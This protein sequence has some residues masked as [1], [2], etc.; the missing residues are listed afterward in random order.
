MVIFSNA[1][2]LY[3]YQLKLDL[4]NLSFW[5]SIRRIPLKKGVLK[6]RLLRLKK[7]FLCPLNVTRGYNS[8]VSLC[9][10]QPAVATQGGLCWCNSHIKEVNQKH[11][12]TGVKRVPRKFNLKCFLSTCQCQPIH[13]L[14]TKTLPSQKGQLK[15][16]VQLFKVCKNKWS[17]TQITTLPTFGCMLHKSLSI[18]IPFDIIADLMSC[19]SSMA[20]GLNIL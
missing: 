11:Y 19:E 10:K 3:P 18:F 13:K 9:Y 16:R 7:V 15:K 14:I 1:I 2:L 8:L 4:V 5:S 12:S 17:W 6:E 20:G